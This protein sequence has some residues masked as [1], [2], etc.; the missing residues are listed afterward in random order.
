MRI[1]LV[2]NATLLITLGGQRL[3]VDPM[4]DA[5]GTRPSVDGS[6]HPRPNP[7]VELPLPADE[8][9]RE[10]DAVLVTHLH[11]DHFDGTAARVIANRFRV[12]CQPGDADKLR[13][14]GVSNVQVVEERT[15]VG[16]VYVWRT[17]GRHGVGRIADKL[18]PVSGFV[19]TAGSETVY[20]A[21]DTIW[22]DE[23]EEAIGRHR[24]DVVVVNAAGA[25]F[26]D[27]EQ[28]VMDTADVLALCAARPGVPVV[29]VHLEAIDH[30]LLTRTELRKATDHLPVIVPE[31]GETLD[32]PWTTSQ[33]CGAWG[34]LG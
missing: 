34:G 20:V 1:Q 17:S 30:C 21:G 25:R 11:T 13:R 14:R 10:V 2:R 16:G 4:F 22:C 26:V 31:D 15:S 24:P 23:V 19:L 8:L 29:A 32:L 28:L 12:L 18:G 27:S 6:P 3:L 5:A 9:L 7:L 33:Y